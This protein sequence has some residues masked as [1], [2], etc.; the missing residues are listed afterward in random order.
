MEISKLIN[1]IRETNTFCL[2]NF[3]SYLKNE[4]FGSGFDH[5][6]NQQL[7]KIFENDREH[8]CPT[9]RYTK[10]LYLDRLYQTNFNQYLAKAATCENPPQWLKS[11]QNKYRDKVVCL[12]EELW[13]TNKN[14]MKCTLGFA[15]NTSEL[16]ESSLPMISCQTIKLA[17]LIGCHAYPNNTTTSGK[18]S[19][20]SKYLHFHTGLVPIFD[21]NAKIGANTLIDCRRPKNISEYTWYIVKFWSLLNSAYP[22][23]N[24]SFCRK[25]IKDLDNYL[26]SIGKQEWKL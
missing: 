9:L 23:A 14:E 20:A 12:V 11:S 19:F 7:Y 18:I 16:T 6:F 21:R 15:K 3:H 10:F 26:F 25:Q 17:R 2:N 22:N 13:S 8:D 5:P 1:K 4:N 24:N